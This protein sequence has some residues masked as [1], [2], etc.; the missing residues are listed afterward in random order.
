PL[1]AVVI[2]I[3]EKHLE[4]AGKVR[5]AL[6]AGGVRVHVDE[7]NEK[8]NAKIREHA[9]QRVPFLLVVGDKEAQ[10]G[11]VNIRTRGSDKTRDSS[12][13]EF[14]TYIRDLIDTKASRLA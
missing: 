7:R 11:T 4:Y 9:L 5:E 1:Q 10:A 8:M 14:V 13:P 3:S 12:L 6:A 2:P